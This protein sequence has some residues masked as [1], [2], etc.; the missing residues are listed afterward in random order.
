MV[1]QPQVHGQL[2]VAAAALGRAPGVRLDGAQDLEAVLAAAADGAQP[3][4]D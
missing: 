3:S 2:R 1:R 4:L